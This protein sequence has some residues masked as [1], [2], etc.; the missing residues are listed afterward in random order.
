M[1][2]ALENGDFKLNNQGKPY[3][4]NAIEETI[5]RCKILLNIRQ[6]CFVYNKLLGCNLHQLNKADENIQG[7]AL[8]L[9]KEALMPVVQ[10]SVCSVEPI[11]SEDD[12]TLKIKI[13]AYNQYADLEVTV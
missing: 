8:L 1:D 6:G 10:V 11:V 7:N 13:K 4:V 9:V 5:Q 2:T 3:L 12:I